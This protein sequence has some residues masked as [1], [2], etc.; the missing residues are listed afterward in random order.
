MTPERHD[1]QHALYS[2]GEWQMNLLGCL[3]LSLHLAAPLE[4]GSIYMK[5][6]NAALHYHLAIEHNLRAML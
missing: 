3:V 4:W 5:A 2:S 6:A 1:Q